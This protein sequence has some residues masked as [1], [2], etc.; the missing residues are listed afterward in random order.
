MVVLLQLFSASLQKVM[1]M[2]LITLLILFYIIGT[3]C[4]SPTVY[5]PCD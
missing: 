3:Q 4:H 5:G 1:Q 2:R